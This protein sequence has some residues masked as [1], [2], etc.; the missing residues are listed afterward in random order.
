VRNLHHIS[1]EKK[2]QS[3]LAHFTLLHESLTASLDE[4]AQRALEEKKEIKLEEAEKRSDDGKTLDSLQK[5]FKQASANTASI[6][7]A[8]SMAQTLE[9]FRDGLAGMSKEDANDADPADGIEKVFSLLALLVQNYK[10]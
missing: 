3:D 6:S 1:A 7:K 10:Y 2:F 5:R 9:K 4:F 8:A